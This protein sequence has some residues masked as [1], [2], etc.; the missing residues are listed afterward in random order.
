MVALGRYKPKVMRLY[1]VRHGQ[2]VWNA[3]NRAQGHKDI[4]L[5]EKGHWQAKQLDE[6]LRHLSIDRVVGSDMTRCV[7]TASYFCDFSGH[8]YESRSD[9]RE[10]TFGEMEGADYSDLH[11][12]MRAEGERL[13]LPEWEV[14]PPGGESMA[15]VRKRLT[16]F[17]ADLRS[18]PGNVLVVSHGGAL[19]Q[20]LGRL[21]NGTPETP[22]SF[23][24]H[25]C[26]LSVLE[27]RT[28]GSFWIDRLNDCK[29]LEEVLAT[30]EKS[31]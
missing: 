31:A 20:L 9:L 23:R 18:T 11:R 13:G 6:R 27:R 19:A 1:L 21:V 12:W 16:K 17:E 22:R 25:N 26:S 15:D 3:T 14:R 29:H 2:T 7:Q 4:E 5:D 10:R 24:F 30:E 28:D 8:P